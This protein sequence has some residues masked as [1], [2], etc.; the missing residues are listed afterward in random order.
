MK[1]IYLIVLLLLA[2]LLIWYILNYDCSRCVRK[3]GFDANEAIADVAS[4]YNTANM[5]ITNLTTTGTLNAQDITTPKINA[6]NVT[7]QD[8]Q[9]NT[10]TIQNLV[11]PSLNSPLA[12]TGSL[13]ST[14][15]VAGGIK[16][17]DGLSGY[18]GTKEHSEI[19]NQASGNGDRGLMLMGNTASPD[20][21]RKV[22]V[23]DDL[24]V[25]G[26]T[27]IVGKT[28]FRIMDGVKAT[29]Q[30]DIYSDGIDSTDITDCINK[31]SVHKD[32]ICCDFDRSTNKC[33]CKKAMILDS[34]DNNHTTAF[35]I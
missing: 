28:K 30:F 3:E 26:N 35:M 8:V 17:S 20:N 6:T 25:I 23:Y 31:C 10:A 18:G 34:S 14:E 21:R 33:Y 32:A 9:A 5:K 11:A 13:T 4:L 16:L 24:K 12:V 29:T 22:V 27:N 15:L 7:S 19:S 2:T 1:T